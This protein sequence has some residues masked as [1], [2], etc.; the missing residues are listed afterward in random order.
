MEREQKQFMFYPGGKIDLN[1]GVAGNVKIIGWQRASIM[2]E[3]EKVFYHLTADEAKLLSAQYPLQL[4]WTQTTATIGTGSAAQSGAGVEIN[5]NVYVPKE[6][7]DLKIHMLQGDLA[8]GGIN[9]WIEATLKEGTIEASSL[10]GYF[11]AL[12]QKGDLIIEMADKRWNGHGFYAVTQ[13]GS[14]QLKLPMEFSC[15]LQL[16]TRNGDITMD[17]PEQLVDGESVP[18]HA[19]TN[20]N[21]RS[22]TATVGGGGSPVNLLTYV[23]DVHLST[24]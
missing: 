4:R 14:I 8:L 9:G 5:L 22:V 18:L 15:A 21:A 3:V 24:K 17:Y 20:K 13:K 10:S 16:A 19:V 23:G 1:A 7:T 2:I 11:S 12:T 6:K